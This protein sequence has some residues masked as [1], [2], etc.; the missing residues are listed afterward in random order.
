MYDHFI[1]AFLPPKQIFIKLPYFISVSV[2]CLR[3]NQLDE[4]FWCNQ[5]LAASLACA[6]ADPF[7]VITA[8]INI[9]RKFFSSF[10]SVS[11]RPGYTP[12]D[13]EVP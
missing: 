10:Q 6:D 9:C 3:M 12:S 7:M 8:F 11:I 2:G 1:T 13:L 4:I 5:Y